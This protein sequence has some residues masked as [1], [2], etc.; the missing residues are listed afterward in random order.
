MFFFPEITHKIF[1]LS[2]TNCSSIDISK[3][4]KMKLKNCDQMLKVRGF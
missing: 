4:R 1:D 3:S 2:K